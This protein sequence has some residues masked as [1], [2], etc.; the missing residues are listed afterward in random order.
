MIL[1]RRPASRRV[2][3]IGGSDDLKLIAEVTLA[4]TR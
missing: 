3:R 1:L 2:N 4:G